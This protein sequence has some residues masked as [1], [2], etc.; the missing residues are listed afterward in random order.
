MLSGVYDLLEEIAPHAHFIFSGDPLHAIRVASG[1]H[2]L[3]VANKKSL[4]F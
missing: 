3:P 2:S 1:P 4:T